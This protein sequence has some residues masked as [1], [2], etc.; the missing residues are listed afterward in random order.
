MD[1]AAYGNCRLSKHTEKLNGIYRS[2]EGI[3]YVGDRVVEVQSVFWTRDDG[4]ERRWLHLTLQLGGRRY[5]KTQDRH[6]FNHAH[7]SRMAR[8]FVAETEARVRT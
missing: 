3:V 1:T 5:H 8:E 7:L 4:A 6:C 2:I